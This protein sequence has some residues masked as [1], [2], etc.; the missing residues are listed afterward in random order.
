MSTS[1]HYNGIDVSKLTGSDEATQQQRYAA[2]KGMPVLFLTSVFMCKGYWIGTIQ[3]LVNDLV[4]KGL[5]VIFVLNE[6]P[7]DHVLADQLRE[8]K[9]MTKCI[10]A[11]IADA[12]KC[13]SNIVDAYK[14]SGLQA[15]AVF[16]P[17]EE[18]QCIVG[19][20]AEAIGMFGNPKEAAQAARNKY[21]TRELCAAA[22]L[23]FPKYARIESRDHLKQIIEE[24]GLPLVLKPSSGA[25]S[26]GVV[27]CEE[28]NA[29]LEIYDHLL[30][31]LLEIV[32]PSCPPFVLAEQYMDGAE[33]DCDLLFW[34]GECV[35]EALTDNWPTKEPY[36]LEDGYNH[37]SIFPAEG[38][39]ELI[40]YSKAC[41]KALGFKQGCFHVELKYTDKT[42]LNAEKKG[43]PILIEVNPRVG[44]GQISQY[45][46]IIYGVAL[47]INFF[48]TACG[49]PINPPRSPAKCALADYF[50]IPNHTGYLASTGFLDYMKDNP[51]V[52]R[53]QVT[54][55]VGDYIRGYDN[56]MPEWIG[57]FTVKDTDIH[58]C[59]EYQRELI[60]KLPEVPV[61]QTPPSKDAPAPTEPAKRPSISGVSQLP[62]RASNLNPEDMP[63]Y[64]AIPKIPLFKAAA[65]GAVSGGAR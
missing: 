65:S 23:A 38:Q 8:K 59:L 33:F 5:D 25:G 53:T 50:V 62:R 57:S 7:D 2:V 37:P 61:T 52:I 43:Q 12:E 64:E 28:A 11:D 34:N 40:E 51:H 20:V 24:W 48:L 1:W 58:K 14:S 49:V 16:S 60:N 4:F 22:N 3:H 29:T 56:G 35:F 32:S 36:F 13:S 63:R 31:E 18:M 42:C 41:V 15:H 6:T 45:Y 30:K 19:E 39:R 46:K 27:K 26:E 9:I 47:D 17:Y 10:F 44:G 54:K 55:K 21:R